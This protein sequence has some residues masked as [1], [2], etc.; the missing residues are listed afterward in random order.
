IDFNRDGDWADAGEQ[1]ATAQ[2]LVA[3]VNTLTVQTP[4]SS[5]VAGISFARFRLSSQGGLAVT[6]LAS[7][8]EVED[9][10]VTL[11]K[12]VENLD[13]GDAPAPY[14][15]VL[16]DNGARHTLRQRF[17]L[18]QLID[19]EPDGQ[20]N[21]TATG[22]DQP[23]PG[24][25]G[26]DEDGVQFVTTPFVPTQTTKVNVTLL[27]GPGRL[28]AWIDFN[29]DGDWADPGEQIF[30]SQALVAG[31]NALEFKTPDNA[32]AGQSFA[33]FRLSEQG[34]LSYTGP[35]GNGEVEDYL[36]RIGTRPEP[37]VDL[38]VSKVDAPDPVTVGETLTYNL[39]VS[40]SGETAATG[41]NL[42]DQLPSTVTIVSVTPD[43]GACTVTAGLIDCNW[44]VVPAHTTVKVTVRV[45]PNAAGTL[46]N[47]VVTSCNE[48]ERSATNNSRTITTTVVDRPQAPC[49][50][51][52]NRGTN[53]WLTFPGNYAPDPDNPIRLSLGIV[54]QRLTTGT[55]RIPGLGFS[56]NF[57]IPGSMEI[58]I[59]LPKG[60]D[61]GGAIDLIEKKGIHVTASAEVAVFGLNK[62]NFTTDGFLGLPS[63]VVG[64]G[65]LVQAFKN[66]QTG[67][68]ELN[69]TQFAIVANEDATQ[70]SIR[71]SV[72]TGTR[73]AGVSYTITLHRG[74]T[75]QLRNTNDAPA[76]LSG[77]MI[78]ADKPI[79]VFAGHQV[80]N[81]A[82][83][84]MFYCDYLV[85]Q[86]VSVER[87]GTRF[88]SMPFATRVNGDTFR[89]AALQNNTTV[90][91][92]GSPSALLNAG[93]MAERILSGPTTI[94]SDKPI[95][96]TQY[97]NSS[98]FDG[99]VNSDPHMIVLQHQG[100]YLPRVPFWTP[101]AGF[102]SH[103]VNVIAPTAAI[104]T[105]TLDGVAIPAASFTPIPGSGYSGAQMP[106]TPGAHLVLAN[107]PVGVVCYGWAEYESYG[108]PGGMFF[109][110]TQPP[111]FI[112]PTVPL[113]VNL[114]A[115]STGACTAPV[116]DLRQLVQVTDNCGMPERI[117]ITQTPSPGTMVGPGV[118]QIVLSTVD[119]K[120]NVGVAIVP[121]RVIDE[122]PVVL[123]CPQD[124]V[125]NCQNDEGANVTFRVVARSRCNDQYEVESSPASGSFFP[126]GTTTV[127]S[128]Y[129]DQ[130][131][132]TQ[133]CTFKVTV[134]CNPTITITRVN[135][136]V[137]LAWGG[138]QILQTSQDITGP[139][140]TVT[141]A[142]PPYNVTPTGAKGYFR[143]VPRP[144]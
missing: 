31:V 48:P 143:I 57:T 126:I 39:A 144:Q 4:A 64:R 24:A 35:G 53:F 105:V 37:T 93:E 131:G 125:V 77:T 123:S 21:A 59:P 34:V 124:M 12:A 113:Q 78:L 43:S 11:A 107:V 72:T 137:Q 100:Q 27:S 16:K 36:V 132:K 65:Y 32:V 94:L 106:V 15:T 97:A 14:P 129:T 114:G 90:L 22:D 81:V 60:A 103:Y 76:D 130:T 13:F 25:G 58:V 134:Q 28:D 52:T 30:T 88:M 98:D 142:R 92:N 1:I 102:V 135:N 89:F 62:V 101:S 5:T 136:Q 122:T 86:L 91:V 49:D 138:D 111:Q 10:Q 69:G 116:P 38:I 67:V 41:V 70:V 109:G 33:R 66:T 40:N 85:E 26:G 82:T 112:G 115:T 83:K 63:D 110:D 42:R 2:T 29:R 140:T 119:A 6:G 133:T 50:D 121:F 118:H 84:D 141:N 73:T 120:G 17:V 51:R 3:G 56:T 104:G 61:L 44:S 96:V 19:L 46:T 18:G 54:G 95:L 75:Y 47:T 7:D 74:Q 117:I 87:A 128:T 68:P 108:Y 9:Y 8:G 99:R 71:P 23:V 20:P 55:V 45:I 139:W 127:T 80:A 79:S